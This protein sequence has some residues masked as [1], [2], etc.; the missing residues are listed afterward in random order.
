VDVLATDNRGAPLP[1][2][3]PAD[4]SILDNGVRQR[5]VS[6]EYEQLPLHVVLALDA[7]GSVDGEARERLVEAAEAFLDGLREPDRVTLVVFTHEIRVH[8][9]APGRRA[10]AAAVIR[11]LVPAGW[12]SAFDA[13][14]VALMSAEK[15]DLR[16]L[17]VLLSDGFDNKSW[18]RL[19]D[20]LGA[21]R[22]VDTVVYSVRVQPAGRPSSRK[23]PWGAIGTRGALAGTADFL[24]TIAV[25]TGGR[26]FLADNEHDVR[27]ALL[28]VLEEFRQR[29]VL[30]YTPEHVESGGWHS[31]EVGLNGRA[32]KVTAR[33]GYRRQ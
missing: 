21:A 15:P 14:W 31:L 32:G 2:L 4:F 13:T 25:E 28:R 7:S 9:I 8:A 20:V 24:E 30:S 29:Y 17:V 1:R 3:G 12:T 23:T 33:R 16:S 6:V 18:L 26:A 22:S 5:I 10:D 19:D 27:P 11:G